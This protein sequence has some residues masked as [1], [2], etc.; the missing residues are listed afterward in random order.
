MTKFVKKFYCPSDAKRL[1][2]RAKYSQNHIAM[3]MYVY[4]RPKGKIVN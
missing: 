1:S 4:L 3:L 2:R